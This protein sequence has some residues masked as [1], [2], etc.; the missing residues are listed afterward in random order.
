MHVVYIKF[1]SETILQVNC[2]K[3]QYKTLKLNNIKKG[4]LI[5]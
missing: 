3:K 4:N 2:L 5:N 1:T